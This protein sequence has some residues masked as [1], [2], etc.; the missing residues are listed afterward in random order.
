MLQRLSVP[1]E[2]PSPSAAKSA[3][4]TARKL[5]AARDATP[6]KATRR[7]NQPV[8]VY[9]DETAGR[10][11]TPAYAGEPPTPRSGW[12]S[13]VGKFSTRTP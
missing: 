1:K 7:F 2:S 3:R 13:S 8:N 6:S 12:L 11:R 5:A 9:E 10:A 4:Q